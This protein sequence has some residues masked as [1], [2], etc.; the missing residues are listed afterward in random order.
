MR[1]I[2][3]LKQIAL[4]LLRLTP[5]QQAG[6]TFDLSRK[7]LVQLPN[8]SLYVHPHDFN[9]QRILRLKSYEPHVT[10]ILTQ[11]LAPGHVVLDIGANLGYFTLLAH[12]LTQPA[13]RVIAFEPNPQNQQLIYQ[14]ILH[15]NAQDNITL[16]PY[17]A[18][19]HDSPKLLRFTTVGSNGGVASSLVSSQP[20]HL[21][22]PAKPVDEILQ[23]EPRINLIKI[24]IE[25]HEP[26]AIRG[27]AKLIKKHHPIILT[28]FHPWA[29][30]NNHDFPPLDY[31]NLLTSLNYTLAIIQPS[32]PYK[33][34]QL[35]T[36]EIMG[37]YH[38]LSN[39]TDH[40]DLIAYPIKSNTK[41]VPPIPATHQIQPI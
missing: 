3:L 6:R 12:A 17:A 7:K 36:D 14:S 40:L 29:M 22:V 27:M 8:F 13:G 5:A 2:P 11:S 18:S 9:G 1:I 19:D 35:T 10:Q 34:V 20:H 24:D 25:S 32:P 30:K 31:L 4:Y 28:E 23:N 21:I 39:P 41:L 15:N 38:N 16:Y 26:F 33:T 37:Y